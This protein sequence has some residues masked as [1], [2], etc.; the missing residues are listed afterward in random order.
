M[1]LLAIRR[2]WHWGR[3]LM[4]PQSLARGAV[5]RRR[6]VAVPRRGNGRRVV[7]RAV[8]HDGCAAACCGR[9]RRAGGVAPFVATA[10][11]TH[12]AGLDRCIRS[13][14]GVDE[15]VLLPRHRPRPAGELGGHRVHRADRCRGHRHQ[16]C[17]I[18]VGAGGSRCWRCDLGGFRGARG[19]AGG[20]V[21]TDRRGAVGRI[22]R[23]GAP[24]CA[25]RHGG[26]T[27]SAWAC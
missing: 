24:G 11:V 4:G 26:R 15:S 5:R 25:F 14:T 18:N 2:D 16:D 12:R 27:A 13:G 3:P 9:G 23:A 17:P 22:H 8:A 7:R 20:A 1:S 6:G 19:A 21:L 10:L